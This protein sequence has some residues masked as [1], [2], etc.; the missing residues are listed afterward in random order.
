M[1]CKLENMEIHNFRCLKD[2]NVQMNKINVLF[3]P[4]GAGKSS[5]LDTIWFI[6]DCAVRGVD[7]ASSVR[8]HGIGLLWEGADRASGISIKLETQASVYEILFGFSQGRI[9]PF[10]GEK[11]YSKELDTNLI[12]RRTG[13]DRVRF[14]NDESGQFDRELREAEKL[15]LTVYSFLYAEQPGAYEADQFLRLVRFYHSRAS[16]LSRIKKFGSESDFQTRLA[17]RGRNLWSVLRNLKDRR[18]TDERYNTIIHYMR[19][20]FPNGLE[21]ILI[22]QTG[23][24]SVYGSF[25]MERHEEPIRASGVSD[26]HIQMLLNLTALFSEGKDICPTIMFD[27]PEVSLHPYALSVFAKAVRFAAEE[28]NRQV[29]IATHS[30]V[31]ISQFE[32]EDILTVELDDETGRTLMKRVTEMND[33][34]DLLDEYAVGSLYMAELIAAQSRFGGTTE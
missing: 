21:E 17:D 9:E 34:S 28:W 26:G 29:F 20:S 18:E 5:F 27:E 31:L 8:D 25:L 12:N 4:N 3:G 13:S 11:L 32:P 7:L 15:A 10:A 14:Y 33:I 1:S 6:R 23:P 30:P 16:E 19:E 22:Q 2:L 24:N